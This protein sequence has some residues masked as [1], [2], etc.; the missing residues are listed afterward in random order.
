MATE[1]K[2]IDL[3]A[4][5]GGIRLGFEQAFGDQIS[6]AF[7]CEWDKYA[8]MT[9]K[10]N[11]NDDF[12]IAGDI[13]SVDEKTIPHFDIC[14]AGFPCQ[15]FSIAGIGGYGRN[16]FND[17]FKGLN[18]GNLFLEVVRICEYH[19]PK[20]IFCENVKGLVTHDK[21]NTFRV[22]REAFKSIGYQVFWK[23]LNSKDFGLAQNR[24][25][26]YIVAF[27]DDLNIGEFV[28]PDGT[29]ED[30]CIRDI[31]EDAPI[32][33][34]YY[35]SDT[36]LAFMQAHKAR[37]AS[38]GHGFGYEIRSLDGIAGTIVCGGMGR[39]RNLIIDHRP[40]D[41]TPQTR[42]KGA[43]NK[44]DIRKLTPRECARLQGFPDTYQLTLSDTRL[45]KQLGNSVA[46]NVIQ[47]IAERI[48]E[49]LTK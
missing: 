20:V 28:F 27:R 1:L 4:G 48:K 23:V 11:F 22:I 49:A 38:K 33:A 34:K 2:S 25:R 46:V 6:T 39:E 7:V 21:G 44:E 3:F 8:Q 40:H 10:A 32:A 43:I 12:E 15:A 29:F 45:Y 14:L 18:R 24:E 35:I 30:V 31:L 47:A 9:Y 41:M 42:I 16:G 26:I 37:H 36:Y 13:L 19:K 5:I 17:D